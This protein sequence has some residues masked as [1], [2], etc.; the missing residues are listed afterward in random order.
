MVVIMTLPKQR[1]VWRNICK[2][3]T[4]SRIAGFLGNWLTRRDH[5]KN[6]YVSE[7]FKSCLHFL[8]FSACP[9]CAWD[10]SVFDLDQ[11]EPDQYC[12]KWI[13]TSIT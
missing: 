8:H 12:N 9:P 5:V 10:P 4:A 13:D 1:L 6:K 3:L 2:S 11:N 7:I